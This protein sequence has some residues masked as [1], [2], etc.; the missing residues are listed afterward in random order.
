MD[1]H[2]QQP[3]VT[4]SEVATGAASLQSPR[5]RGAPTSWLGH[6]KVWQ[7]LALIAA[8][9]AIPL[10]LFVSLYAAS[11]QQDVSTALQKDQGARF[12]REAGDLVQLVPQHRG[13]TNTLRSGNE[14]VAGRRAELQERVDANLAEVLAF[15]SQDER[16]LHIAGKLAELEAGWRD[17]EENLFTLPSS[18]VF[19]MHTAWLQN[20]LFST[21]AEVGNTSKLKFDSE[22]EVVYLSELVTRDLPNLTETLGRMRGYGAGVLASGQLTQQ[23]AATLQAMAAE[24]NGYLRSVD[25]GASYIF[26]AAPELKGALALDVATPLGPAALSST[27][28]ALLTAA[29]PAALTYDSVAYFDQMTKI[30]DAYVVSYNSALDALVDRLNTRVADARRALFLSLGGLM[31]GLAFVALLVVFVARQITQPVG[32][33]A[34]VAGRVGKGD[35]SQFAWVAS[36]DEFGVLAGTFNNAIVSLRDAEKKNEIDRQ[37]SKLLQQNVGAFLDVAMDIADGDFT[38]RGTVSEDALGNVVDAINLMVED[39]AYLLTQTRDA[40]LLVNQGSSEM[41]EITDA[42]TRSAQQQTEEAQGAR[43]RSLAI[44]NSIR[45]MADTADSAAEA[46]ARALQASTQGEE[47]V[48]NTLKGMQSIRN[49]VQAISERSESL[50]SRSDEISEV[51]KS[52]SHI[53]SQ[54]NLLALNAALEAAGAGEAGAR[55]STV[56]AEVQA[57]AEESAVAAG[58]VG[59]LVRAVQTEIKEVSQSVRGGSK[60]VEAGYLV[61]TEAG[62]R[63]KEIAQIATQSADLVRAISSA[64]QAQVSGVEGV[65]TSITSI[66]GLSERAQSRVNEG[67]EAAARL[68]TLS[69]ELTENLSRFRLA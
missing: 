51:V 2:S 22:Q 17:I 62:E 61:A 69:N 49:E 4:K 45:H 15:E 10:T 46:S 65:S 58:R 57:L 9:L 23:N 1:V 68:Q 50:R 27:N 47:A 53:A 7:K 36:R 38:K 60:E 37:Q 39:L 56:A 55:F 31:L 14:S 33:L 29:N 6:L 48:A 13:I 25:L 30:I 20:E 28:E 21:L 18:E 59:G 35:L 8:V 44:T 11:L 16:N 66:A 26:E 63:L 41:A 19:N 64:A 40:A 5:Q 54:I 43:E 52:M 3:N 42:V 32:E 34:T 24:V 12:L 67:R